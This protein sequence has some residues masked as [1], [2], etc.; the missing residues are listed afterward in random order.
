MRIEEYWSVSSSAYVRRSRGQF[1]Q[2]KQRFVINATP[3]G[4]Q[5]SLNMGGSRRTHDFAKTLLN[6]FRFQW[7]VKFTKKNID[8]CKGF[9]REKRGLS[10]SVKTD[11]RPRSHDDRGTWSHDR[12]MQSHAVCW[13]RLFDLDRSLLVTWQS[14]SLKC[15]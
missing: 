11:R 14:R 4:W 12:T 7:R 3:I 9:P 2:I 10:D 8:I 6:F 1:D 5:L 15:L 13:F